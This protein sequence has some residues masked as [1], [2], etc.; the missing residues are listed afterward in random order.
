MLTRLEFKDVVIPRG[1]RI[2]PPVVESL[3]A[4]AREGRDLLPLVVTI[5]QGF[6][7]DSFLYGAKHESAIRQG[8]ATLCL[9][10]PPA[11][12]DADLRPKGLY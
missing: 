8:S 4:A 10:H 1:E 9:Y 3:V 5:I 2:L 12:V 6:G 7:F 11:G